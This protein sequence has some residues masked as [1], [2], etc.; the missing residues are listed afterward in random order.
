MVEKS[1]DVVDALYMK[2]QA[3]AALSVAEELYRTAIENRVKAEDRESTKPNLWQRF[4]TGSPCPAR[5]RPERTSRSS[6]RR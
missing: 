1:G 2:A 4:K 3:T 5:R 6:G